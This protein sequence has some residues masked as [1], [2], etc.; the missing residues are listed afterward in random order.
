MINGIW[1]IWYGQKLSLILRVVSN[2]MPTNTITAT[3]AQSK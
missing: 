1:N 3:H 2:P